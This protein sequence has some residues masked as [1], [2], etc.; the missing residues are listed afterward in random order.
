[1]SKA[2]IICAQLSTT[3]SSPDRLDVD[4]VLSVIERVKSALG[5]DIL[6]V[7]AREVPEIF[8]LVTDPRGRPARQIFLWYNVLSDI[9]AME[10]SDLVVNWRGQRSRGWGGW[11]EKRAEVAETFR[12]ACPNNPVAQA[13][14]LTRLRELLSRYP[15]DGVFLDKI[16]FPSP[17]NGLE[18]VVSCF[19]DHCRRAAAAI[20]LDLGEVARIFERGLSAFETPRP[21]GRQMERASWLAILAGDGSLLS[22]FL[23]FRSDSIERLVAQAHAEA[24]RFGRRL[25]IDL[26]SPGLAPLVGQDYGSLAKYCDWV[27]PMTYRVAQGPAG[28]RL[29]IP[30]LVEGATR[31]LGLSEASILAWASRH[32]PGFEADTLRLTREHAVPMPVIAPEIA[33]AVRLAYPV[34]VLFGL[35]LVC[36][37]GVV[38]ITPEQVIDMVRAG[39]EANADGAILSWDLMHAPMDGVRALAAAV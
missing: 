21:W 2:W 32:L 7:G 9:P 4:Q 29:E 27:K 3:H 23:R 17:A 5:L 24:S 35:E 36:H 38:E 11:A 19:C 10:D 25:S 12:F 37:P 31:M 1:M 13:K 8:R 26:F 30:A 15:F 6:I 18:E 14:T 33:H 16:R 28:L 34:P 22:R 39:R 20:G